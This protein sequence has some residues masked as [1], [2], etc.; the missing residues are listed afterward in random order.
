MEK[1]IILRDLNRAPSRRMKTR[2]ATRS[3][4]PPADFEFET[5]SAPAPG[6]APSPTPAALRT[7]L[8][9]PAIETATLSARDVQDA[10]RDPDI[11]ALAIDMPTILLAPVATD[12]GSAAAAGDNWGITAIGAAGSPFTGKGVSVCVLDTGI[13]VTHPAFKGVI[14]DKRDFTT[15]VPEGQVIGDQP[16]WDG[17]GHGTHCAGTIFG[18]NVDGVRIGVAPGVTSAMIGKVLRDSGGGTTEMLFAGLQWAI[19]SGVDVVSMSIGFDFP[20]LVEKRIAA[21]LSPRQATS[22]ALVAYRANLRLFDSLMAMVKA[23]LPFDEGT[24]IVAASGNESD[25]ARDIHIA[26]SIPAAADGMI[27]VG[28]VGQK[29]GKEGLANFSNVM[30][31]VCAPGV[32]IR[33]AKAGGGLIEMSGTSMATPHVAGIAAL[34]W[35]HLR[36]KSANHK[37]SAAEVVSGMM[38]AARQEDVF[39]TPFSKFD[40]GAGLVTVP[41]AVA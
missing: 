28:A 19:T 11:E 20:G 27:S 37:T 21:G 34:W 26:V 25:H 31:A 1:Y 15:G 8:P 14:L 18:R 38:T 6:G 36:S 3:A 24:V 22:D 33:S 9:A 35:E 29:D 16:G 23:R 17:N 39:A 32:A 10:A 30:P 5:E 40:F 12:A 13:D 2:S 4:A 7:D 41:R